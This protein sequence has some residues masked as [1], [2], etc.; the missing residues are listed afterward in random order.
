M[1]FF[2][3]QP[4]YVPEELQIYIHQTHEKALHKSMGVDD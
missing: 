4:F 2:S 3:H 1:V